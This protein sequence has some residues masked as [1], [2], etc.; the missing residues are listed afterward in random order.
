MLARLHIPKMGRPIGD[1]RHDLATIGAEG[2]RQDAIF[3][4]QYLLFQPAADIPKS[5]CAIEAGRHY[6]AAVGAESCASGML[7]VSLKYRETG[8]G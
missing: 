8:L 5:R 3:M 4:I 7:L 2:G 1:G 6:L